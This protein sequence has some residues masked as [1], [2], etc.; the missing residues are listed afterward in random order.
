MVDELEL[1][2]R[3]LDRLAMTRLTIRLDPE[4]EAQYE[5]LAERERELIAERSASAN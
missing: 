4:L 3:Q 5:R 2:R 1:V